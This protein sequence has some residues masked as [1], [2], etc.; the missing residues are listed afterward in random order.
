MGNLMHIRWTFTEDL[1]KNN[2]PKFAL[3]VPTRCVTVITV[4][5]RFKVGWISASA[6][7]NAA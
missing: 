5:I 6:S 3:I 4:K 7:T 2:V 1:L